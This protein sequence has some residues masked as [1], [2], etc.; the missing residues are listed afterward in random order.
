MPSAD[1]EEDV[2]M[3]NE[4]LEEEE[5]DEEFDDS[6][7]PLKFRNYHPVE[8]ILQ[9]YKMEQPNVPNIAEEIDKKLKQVVEANKTRDVLNIAPKK[10]NWDL[11]RDLSKKMDLLEKRTQQAITNMVIEKFKQS[12][13][14]NLE[15]K[16]NAVLKA[17]QRT[18]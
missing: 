6:P 1:R 8:E 9:K 7:L 18:N 15:Q 11:K 16:V 2:V 17:E 10:A 5:E 13:Q 12:T 3:E 4:E 14:D